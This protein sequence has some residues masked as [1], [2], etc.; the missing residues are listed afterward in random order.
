MCHKLH[1]DGESDRSTF[2]IPAHQRPADQS[3]VTAAQ[4][5][6]HC[7]HTHTPTPTPTPTPTH[8]C[9][10]TH[11]YTHTHTH[12]PIHTHPYTHTHTHAHTVKYKNKHDIV[13]SESHLYA[14][15]CTA[16]ILMN[17]ITLPQAKEQGLLMP[18]HKSEPQ[19]DY[20]G[21][22]VIEPMRG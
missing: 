6:V 13:R 11:P 10:H 12:T 8:P 18:M 7:I 17:V 16:I 1:G 9:T 2:G 14:G 20:A 15:V 3:G 19:E 22:A 4:K 5:G 21:G